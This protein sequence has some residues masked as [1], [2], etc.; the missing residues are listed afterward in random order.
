MEDEACWFL[1]EDSGSTTQGGIVNLEVSPP[2]RKQQRLGP[3]SALNDPPATR[4]ISDARSLIG[5]D[6][7]HCDRQ[8]VALRAG[9]SGR[10]RE[11]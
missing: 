9:W 4:P 2:F 8:Q 10:R 6:G 1:D 11:E 5:Q 3:G 7:K